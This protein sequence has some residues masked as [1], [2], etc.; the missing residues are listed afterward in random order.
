MFALRQLL[1]GEI[2]EFDDR[3]AEIII[4]Q[5]RSFYNYNFSC[6]FGGK[7]QGKTARAVFEISPPVSGCVTLYS[8]AFGPY[9]IFCNGV[10]VLDD[11]RPAAWTRPLPAY[12]P[13]ATELKLHDGLNTIIFEVDCNFLNWDLFF[14]AEGIEW[15]EGTLW[16]FDP[17]DGSILSPPHQ[18]RAT[19]LGTANIL[20]G[21][22]RLRRLCRSNR[23]FRITCGSAQ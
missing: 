9:R 13:H 3:F 17:A 4:P 7:F 2:I 8:A 12:E 5:Q 6:E 21:H 18:S 19:L 14:A 22:A 23:Q 20:A 11:D 16:E 1:S 10:K 15:G